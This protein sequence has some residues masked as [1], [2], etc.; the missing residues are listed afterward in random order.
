MSSGVG[1]KCGSDPALLWLWHRSAAVALIRPLAWEPTYA[2]GVALKRQKTKKKK[3][4]GGVEGVEGTWFLLSLFSLKL[5]WSGNAENSLAGKKGIRPELRLGWRA[6]GLYLEKALL[7]GLGG[8]QHKVVGSN[9]LMQISSCLETYCRIFPQTLP[10]SR[11]YTNFIDD[12]PRCWACSLQ[13]Q[14]AS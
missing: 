14:P 3:K 2:V 12:D 11:Y 13:G 8:A 9:A 1:C 4:K 5:C 10:W 7:R 6:M